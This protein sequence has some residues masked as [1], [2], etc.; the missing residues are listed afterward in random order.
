VKTILCLC[1]LSMPWIKGFTW[2]FE[3]DRKASVR[4]A[5]NSSWLLNGP[6]EIRQSTFNPHILEQL[7]RK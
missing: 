2:P 5:L 6:E 4:A 7:R 3:F 1:S